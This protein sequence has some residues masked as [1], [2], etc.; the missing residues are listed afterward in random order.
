MIKKQAALKVLAMLLVIFISVTGM[1]FSVSADN[2]AKVFNNGDEA[3][4]FPVNYDPNEGMIPYGYTGEIGML[5]Y[6]DDN[7]RYDSDKDYVHFPDDL[8]AMEDVY[9]DLMFPDYSPDNPYY[10]YTEMFNCALEV[11]RAKGNVDVYVEE[12]VYYFTES[13]W[14]WGYTNINGVAGKTVF[15]PTKM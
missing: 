13:V 6:L 3:K 15:L 8:I 5:S 12:G 2:G 10:D 4:N 1:P 11:A 7:N 14:L 9:G